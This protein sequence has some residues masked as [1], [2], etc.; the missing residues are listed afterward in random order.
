V[1]IIEGKVRRGEERE[2][3]VGGPIGKQKS[4]YLHGAVTL[5]RI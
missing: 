5:L 3:E 2:D 1:A 4:S